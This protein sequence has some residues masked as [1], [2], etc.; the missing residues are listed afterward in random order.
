MAS[1]YLVVN[2]TTNQ[3]EYFLKNK[4]IISFTKRKY[5]IKLNKF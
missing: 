4:L 3:N 2:N 1:V 5:L